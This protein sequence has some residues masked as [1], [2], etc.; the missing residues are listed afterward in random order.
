MI[1]QDITK[2]I[3]FANICAGE[4][5]AQKGIAFPKQKLR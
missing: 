1:Y 3:K 5:V 2:A 4:V